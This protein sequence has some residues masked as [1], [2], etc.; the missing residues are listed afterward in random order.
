MAADPQTLQLRH[1]LGV[2]GV[3]GHQTVVENPTYLNAAK[4]AAFLM[5]SAPLSLI[6]LPLA[7]QIGDIITGGSRLAS[8]GCR[9]KES[10]R[11]V[12]AG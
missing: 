3:E 7:R 11:A 6:T 12:V 4:A 2:I 1:Y 8:S 10:V 5:T 9:V